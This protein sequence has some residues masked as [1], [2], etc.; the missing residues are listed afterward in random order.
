MI[1][2]GNR[3]NLLYPFMLMLFVVLQKSDTEIFKHFNKGTNINIV[4]SLLN[5]L[6]NIIFSIIILIIENKEIKSSNE[7]RQNQL[8]SQNENGMKDNAINDL[9]SKDSSIKIIILLFL[10]AFFDFAALSGFGEF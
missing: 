3:H 9:V 10:A 8:K 2:I 5:F 4:Y 6:S 7:Q 1:A